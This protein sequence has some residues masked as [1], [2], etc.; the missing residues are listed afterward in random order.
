MAER[1][2]AGTERKQ[3]KPVDLVH[4]CRPNCAMHASIASIKERPRT[5]GAIAS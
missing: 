5:T 4:V 1:Q 2:Q 3:E